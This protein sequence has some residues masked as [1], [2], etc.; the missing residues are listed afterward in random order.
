MGVVEFK[1]DDNPR[2]SCQSECRCTSNFGEMGERDIISQQGAAPIAA[3]DEP[4]CC[5]HGFTDIFTYCAEGFDDGRPNTA[6]PEGRAAG[7]YK[8]FS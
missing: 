6:F 2:C 5:E 8:A 7:Y 4:S 1:N 3:L